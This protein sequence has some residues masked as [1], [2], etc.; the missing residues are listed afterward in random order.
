MAQLLWFRIL[1]I[2]DWSILL[3]LYKRTTF[4]EGLKYKKFS[5]LSDKIC[6]NSGDSTPRSRFVSVSLSCICK[7]MN[8]SGSRENISRIT[9]VDE[10]FQLYPG[11]SVFPFVCL[12]KYIHEYSDRLNLSHAMRKCVFGSLRPGQTQ[13]SLRSHRS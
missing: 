12:D 2:I 7:Y 1:I 9:G 10:I 6:N 5:L 4:C 13:T 11:A 8:M 3:K